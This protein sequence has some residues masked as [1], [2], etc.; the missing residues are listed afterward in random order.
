MYVF[1]DSFATPG[2]CVDPKD[3]FWGLLAQDLNVKE[4]INY[5]HSGIGTS[6]NLHWMMTALHTIM[7]FQ[8][9]ILRGVKV[10]L[11]N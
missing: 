1:G 2:L 10:I 5:S 4:I 11:T 6:T 3:S 9:N 7:N 8:E